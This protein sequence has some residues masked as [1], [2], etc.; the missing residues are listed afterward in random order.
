M[1]RSSFQVAVISKGQKKHAYPETEV[2]GASPSL[3]HTVWLKSRSQS[4]SKETTHFSLVLTFLHVICVLSV[5]LADSFTRKVQF[6]LSISASAA[7]RGRAPAALLVSSWSVE[8][9]CSEPGI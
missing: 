8:S 2:H 6:S 1:N 7:C 9:R 5:L 3:V 4:R